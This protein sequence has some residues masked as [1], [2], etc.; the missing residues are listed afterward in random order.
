LRDRGSGRP[1]VPWSAD[2]RRSNSNSKYSNCL[3][4]DPVG[5]DDAADSSGEPCARVPA[6]CS[7][8]SATHEHVQAAGGEVQ[9]AWLSSLHLSQVE[10]LASA[11]SGHLETLVGASEASQTQ[12][13]QL[14]ARQRRWGG[15]GRRSPGDGRGHSSRPATRPTRSVSLAGDRRPAPLARSV[16]RWRERSMTSCYGAADPIFEGTCTRS[17]P[18]LMVAS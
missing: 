4:P 14:P 16:P 18:V 12:Q 6:P 2:V 7:R 5:R 15:D 13:A 9:A 1:S 11:Q 17:R 3:S 8:A 10:R